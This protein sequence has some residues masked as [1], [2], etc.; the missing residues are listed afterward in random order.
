[1]HTQ[2]TSADYNNNHPYA[3]CTNAQTL[4]TTTMHI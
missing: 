3:Q 1:M 2:S 4:I